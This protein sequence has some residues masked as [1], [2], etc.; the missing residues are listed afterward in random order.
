L[1]RIM[2]RKNP[3]QAEDLK[4]LVEVSRQ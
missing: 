1:R 3:E 4:R 2:L